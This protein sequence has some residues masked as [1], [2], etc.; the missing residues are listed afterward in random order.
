MIQQTLSILK[1]NAV[2]DNNIGNIL[3][4]FEKKN[5]KIV[6]MKISHL[7][8]EEAEGFYIEHI[9]RSFFNS[10]IKF[11]ISSPIVLLVLQ[12]EN[13]IEKNREIMGE[14]D[15]LQAKEGS[16]RKLYGSSIEHNAVHGSDSISAAKREILYFFNSKEIFFTF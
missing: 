9:K 8:K 11:M 3:S 6:A 5:L 7:T 14:T 16:L 12:G 4:I 2:R 1:P 15:P 10:L 13:A